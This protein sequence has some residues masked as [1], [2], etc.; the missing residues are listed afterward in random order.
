MGEDFKSNDP[1]KWAN[2]YRK[3]NFLSWEDNEPYYIGD[4]YDK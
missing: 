2:T 4:D 1:L 3:C